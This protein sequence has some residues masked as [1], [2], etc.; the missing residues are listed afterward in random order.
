VVGCHRVRIKTMQQLAALGARGSG[1]D[2]ADPVILLS[3]V[4]LATDPSPHR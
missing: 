3:R 1:M 2:V 4:L